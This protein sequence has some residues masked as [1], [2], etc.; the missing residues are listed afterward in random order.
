[1]LRIVYFLAVILHS[2]HMENKTYITWSQ[3]KLDI[4]KYFILQFSR[5]YTKPQPETLFSV[6]NLIGTTEYI[7]LKPNEITK[8]LRKVEA[9]SVGE[10]EDILQRA[11]S[12]YIDN[13]ANGLDEYENLESIYS[14][15]VKVNVTGILLNSFK[16]LKMRVLLITTE[17][18]NLGQDFR[19]VEWKIVSHQVW[20]KLFELFFFFLQFGNDTAIITNAPYN[21]TIVE[22]RMVMFH[23]KEDFNE[24]CVRV[25]HWPIR[26]PFITKEEPVCKHW[27][28][29]NSLLE[30][31]QLKPNQRYHMVLESCILHHTH[32]QLEITTL[33]D[34]KYLSA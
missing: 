8:N 11:E 10:T 15:V 1:M 29:T 27:N 2:V 14:I 6:K 17:N 34:R 24:S 30:V 7:D 32:G 28:I 9:L 22:S 21:L 13:N 25:C 12:R 19:Y 33:P 4:I 20:Y 5:N 26:F 16:R 31:K 23:F 18:E 3:P